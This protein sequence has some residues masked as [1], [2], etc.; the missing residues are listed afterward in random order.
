VCVGGG[1]R[2]ATC[3]ARGWRRVGRG[4]VCGAQRLGCCGP[5]RANCKLCA[6]LALSV[7][8]FVARSLSH[9]HNTTLTASTTHPR[10]CHECTRTLP[11]GIKGNTLSGW[12]ETACTTCRR[13]P[14]AGRKNKG[15]GSGNPRRSTG[16]QAPSPHMLV[17]K[18]LQVEQG[19]PFS[20]AGAKQTPKRAGNGLA[21]VCKR[22]VS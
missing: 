15:S 12:A 10:G 19:Y 9:T 6:V 16:V 21:R 11:S 7:P 8:L 17:Q 4:A 2:G 22:R 3:A 20:P 14:Q 1:A 13:R 5:C 18:R